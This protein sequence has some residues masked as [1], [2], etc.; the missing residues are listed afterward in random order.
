MA[1]A[2]A[3]RAGQHYIGTEH[4]LWALAAEGDGVAGHILDSLMVRHL[5]EDRADQAII[6]AGAS[7][8]AVGNPNDEV[9]IRLGP[10]GPPVNYPIQIAV[11]EA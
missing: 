9:T 7:G 5:A 4:L 11:D 6:E 10:G 3:E 2:R 1:G 8:R